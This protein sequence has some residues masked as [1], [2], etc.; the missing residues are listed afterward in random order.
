MRTKEAQLLMTQ[1]RHHLLSMAGESSVLHWSRLCEIAEVQHIFSEYTS[2]GRQ[3]SWAGIARSMLLDVTA[4]TNGV[5]GM[6]TIPLRSVQA[7]DLYHD[8]NGGP[9]WTLLVS[10]AVDVDNRHI[11]QGLPAS[12]SLRLKFE[13]EEDAFAFHYALLSKVNAE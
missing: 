10:T 11:D 1:F 4:Y 8:V 12:S 2:S 13:A 9:E 6:H 3:V 7:L 5:L